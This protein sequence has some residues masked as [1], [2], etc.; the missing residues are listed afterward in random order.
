[1]EK[2]NLFVNKLIELFFLNCAWTCPSCLHSTPL[3]V[4]T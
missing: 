4:Y 1:M 3:N 2:K